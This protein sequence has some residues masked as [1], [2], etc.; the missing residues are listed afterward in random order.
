MKKDELSLDERCQT[1]I[2]CVHMCTK[3]QCA[4]D[5]LPSNYE[6]GLSTADYLIQSRCRI[7][8]VQDGCTAVCCKTMYAPYA[9][10][11]SG[12]KFLLCVVP[13]FT[14][15]LFQ[16]PFLFVKAQVTMISTDQW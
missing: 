16:V 1:H 10:L 5:V 13:V 6:Y 14:C 15:L 9:G 7:T 12:N 11:V 8:P 4:P 3:V 2:Q